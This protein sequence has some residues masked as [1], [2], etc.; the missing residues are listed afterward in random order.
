MIY[1]LWEQPQASG[2]MQTTTIS[3]SGG[4]RPI[5]PN[6]GEMSRLV[7]GDY[8]GPKSMNREAITQ[9]FRS[10]TPAL[11]G[12]G[13]ISREWD[14]T[15]AFPAMRRRLWSALGSAQGDHVR[16][17]RRFFEWDVATP[18][19]AT[20]TP[21]IGC[22]S[23]NAPVAEDLQQAARPSPRSYRSKLEASG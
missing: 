6:A 5:S 11:K 18:A 12:S 7:F 17:L 1:D 22:G 9:Q 13:G 3:A 16:V 23:R 19:K 21:A 20:A 2:L 10:S 14:T 8:F 4:V 15:G